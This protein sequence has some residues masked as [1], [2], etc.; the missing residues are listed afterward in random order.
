MPPPGRPMNPQSRSA[1]PQGRQPNPQGR[2]LQGNPIQGQPMQGQPMQGQP[3][4]GQPMQGNP[5][6]PQGQ[7]RSAQGRPMQGNPVNPQPMRPTQGRPMPPNGNGNGQPMPNGGRATA[8]K[9]TN[10]RAAPRPG[11]ASHTAHGRQQP[12][13]QKKK[14]GIIVIT[15]LMVTVLLAIGAGAAALLLVRPPEIQND[16]TIK[17]TTNGDAV[18]V[19]SLLNAGQRVNDLFTFVVGA[20]DEDQT[21]T[22]A[23][24]VA[25]M[26][27]K[28]K[29]INI[30][31]I[32][33]DTMCNNGARDASRKINAAYGMKKGI[34]QTKKEIERI[35]GFQPDKYIIVNFEGIAAIVDAIGGID[36]DVPFRME[37][38]DP[39]QNLEIDL[40]AGNQHLNGKQTVE[41]LRWRH[42]NDY[43]VQY[44]N[45]DEGRVENQQKFL[46][47][48]AKQVF[49]VKN[50]TKIKQI[51]NAVFSN[52]KTDF[53]AGELLWMGMQA[54]QIDNNNIKFFTLPGYGQMSTAGGS[55]AYSF[56]FP[57]YQDTLQLVNAYFNPYSEPITTLDLVTGPDSSSGRTYTIDDSEDDYLWGNNSGSGPAVTGLDSSSNSNSHHSNSN[58]SSS[59][60]SD[61][62]SDS[63][64]GGSSSGGSSSGS[65]SWSDDTSYDNGYDY[66]DDSG[67][68][69]SDN[70][71]DYSDNSG[72]DYSDNSGDYSDDNSGGEIIGGGEITGGDAPNGDDTNGDASGEAPPL[73]DGSGGDGSSDD[74]SSSDDPFSSGDDTSGDGNTEPSGG[75]DSSG[76]DSSYE[77]PSSGGDEPSY[78]EPSGGEEP[79]YEEPSYEEPS[80]GEEPSYEEPSGG[81]E[82]PSYEEPS[83]GE[84]DG[85]VDPEA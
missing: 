64:S 44:T 29:K 6:N 39:S 52:V 15:V 80:G 32:P 12:Q 56:Y 66:N 50:V 57:Y 75:G 4:Q 58:N 42:N 48:V 53:T 9:P 31:N 51:A 40:Y 77:E 18:E 16:P 35:M 61:S 3:M 84:D 67:Y 68:D 21:R 33:R 17:D 55:V 71:Y 11:H 26:N 19:D 27:A 20:V 85:A 24:M 60:R 22:D 23:L 46:K 79:S 63:S 74:G 8:P 45:G 5:A 1:N 41:F 10:G 83:G 65:S 78:E 54:M 72:Y 70:G 37:Y 14:R 59:H 38:S 28:E 69:Y 81:G 34:E 62:S 47:E 25:T 76:G 36:Y 82:E 43:S 73:D 2:P 7:P 13:K 49:Q 30:M